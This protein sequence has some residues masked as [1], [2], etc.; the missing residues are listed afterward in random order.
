MRPLLMPLAAA[1]T[2][3]VN[4]FDF[5]SMAVPRVLAY[6]TYDNGDPTDGTV[7][8]RVGYIFV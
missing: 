4:S 7:D 5:L 2:P 3:V 8:E 6:Y 1:R